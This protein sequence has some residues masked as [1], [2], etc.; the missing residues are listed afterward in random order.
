MD[1]WLLTP[2]DGMTV[3]FSPRKFISSLTFEQIPVFWDRY[4]VIVAKT[5]TRPNSFMPD[6]H[7]CVF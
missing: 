6:E 1:F 7:S 3:S 2:L 4:E 5:P